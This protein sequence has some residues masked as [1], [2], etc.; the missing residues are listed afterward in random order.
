MWYE[1]FNFF[2]FE[3]TFMDSNITGKV[4][5]AGKEEHFWKGQEM[6]REEEAVKEEAKRKEEAS[7]RRKWN[8][9]FSGSFKMALFLPL[10]ILSVEIFI[11]DYWP[12]VRNR[13]PELL[14]DYLF[15]FSM[16]FLIFVC[17]H[18]LSWKM[19]TRSSEP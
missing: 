3:I 14:Y 12:D 10:V 1:P 8:Y 4:Q 5:E 17:Y 7:G 13:I 6:K 2:S 11:L 18:L 19:R 16:I 9:I 15:L